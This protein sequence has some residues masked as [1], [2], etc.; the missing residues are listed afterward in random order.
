MQRIYESMEYKWFEGSKGIPF[1]FIKENEIWIYNPKI[2]GFIKVSHIT[3]LASVLKRVYASQAEWTRKN[4]IS[5]KYI[6][7]NEL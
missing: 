6:F 2:D 1:N 3:A 4:E 7:T 5:E